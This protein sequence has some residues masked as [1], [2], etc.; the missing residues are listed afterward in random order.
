ML[1]QVSVADLMERTDDGLPAAPQI[2]V[3]VDENA[4]GGQL[5]SPA[6]QIVGQSF[7]K[8]FLA[9]GWLLVSGVEVVFGA[10]LV[11]VADLHSAADAFDDILVIA[12]FDQQQ[13]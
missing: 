1:G 2:I 4:K 8:R 10:D 6:F 13:G 11:D 3:S 12:A 9:T 5:L 7:Q